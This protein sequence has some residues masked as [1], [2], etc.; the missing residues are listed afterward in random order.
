MNIFEKLFGEIKLIFLNRSNSPSVKNSVKNKNVGIQIGSI[1]YN[2]TS[3]LHSQEIKRREV[4][5]EIWTKVKYHKQQVADNLKGIKKMEKGEILKDFEYTRK[6]F[7]DN[8]VYLNADF[9]NAFNQ[10]DHEAKIF[11]N[12][13]F[14]ADI[15]TRIKMINYL[16]ESL[17][18]EVR[19]ALQ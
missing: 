14:S 9:I 19:K 8:R 11:V 7:Q 12:A 1:N 16:I 13:S 17:E 10:L 4:V 3:S 15:F 2:E 18:K 5:Q 6:Y